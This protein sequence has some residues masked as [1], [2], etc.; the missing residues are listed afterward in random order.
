MRIEVKKN[1]LLCA[2]FGLLHHLQRHI[3]VQND[4]DI[5]VATVSCLACERRRISGCRDSRR[6]SRQPEIRL[7]S[8]AISCQV[9]SNPK[10]MLRIGN[11]NVTLGEKECKAPFPLWEKD[12]MMMMN[13]KIGGKGKLLRHLPWNTKLLCYF[14]KLRKKPESI[15]IHYQAVKQQ[16]TG[17]YSLSHHS[18]KLRGK[19]SLIDIIILY[20]NKETTHQT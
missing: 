11:W 17:K 7:H 10:K 9:T 14:L 5:H 13:I 20:T 18:Q 12:Q 6:E 15:T 4:S 8:Q 1:K 3:I 16:S 19:F 2:K